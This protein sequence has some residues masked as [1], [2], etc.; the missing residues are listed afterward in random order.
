[1][2]YSE[3]RCFGCMNIYTAESD[4]CPV[5]GYPADGGNPAE[6]LP[7]G[8][9][10]AERYTVGRVLSFSGT[11]ACYIAYDQTG[12]CPVYLREFMPEALCHRSETGA[13]SPKESTEEEFAR[14]CEQFETQ[15]RTLAKL[16]DLSVM[17]PVYDLFKQNGTS[18]TVSEYLE[19]HT[20]SELLAQKGGR[21]TWNDTRKL[22]LP[23]LSSLLSCHAAG[24]HHLAICPQ[25]LLV[26]ESGRLRLTGF[27]LV[28]VRR[29]TDLLEPQLADGYAAPE[30]YTLGKPVGASA[31]VYA[32]AAT[33]F[34]VL[35]GN[36][37]PDGSQRADDGNDLF[38]PTEVANAL[39]EHVAE[40][41]ADA[42]QPNTKLRIPSLTELRDRLSTGM[43]V[44]ALAQEAEAMAAGN[45]E[46]KMPKN[47][48]GKKYAI[49]LCALLAVILIVVGGVIYFKLSHP[50]KN[51]NETSKTAAAPTLT[52]TEKP[53]STEATGPVSFAPNLCDGK[54]DYYALPIDGGV[55]VKDDY[56]VTVIGY[57]YSDSVPAG[58]IV[59]QNPVAGAP[60][61]DGTTISVYLSAGKARTAVPDVTGWKAEHAK[62]YLEALGFRVEIAEGADT[63]V[64][65]GCVFGTWPDA[66]TEPLNGNKVTLRVN[67]TPKTTATQSESAEADEPV[68]DVGEEE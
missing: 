58:Y 18:Y 28:E 36:P 34:R 46:E 31:D 13:I 56:P 5:C 4:A 3:R 64:D 65:V 39:P 30:Q 52:E 45:R 42:L 61:P 9:V 17:I 48:T 44:S 35:T 29:E 20:L 27:D 53:T 50:E 55:R 7:V 2:Q 66:G 47:S 16:R 41:L 14:L 54:Q 8:T 37:P 33:L 22:F 21:L 40:T 19:P 15:G 6:Y 62:I 67:N 51:P 1:M 12:D 26:D 24:L 38:M 23:F 49:L 63:S 10:L 68:N 59:A 32:V 43:V 57:Q 11:T 25:N 60:V